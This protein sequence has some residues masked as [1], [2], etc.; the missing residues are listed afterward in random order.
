MQAY[1]EPE[2]AFSMS[3]PQSVFEIS[4]AYIKNMNSIIFLHM[5][6]NQEELQLKVVFQGYFKACS[7]CFKIMFQRIE[8]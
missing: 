8:L 6:T 1:F 2:Q 4:I 7:K 5:D 3:M